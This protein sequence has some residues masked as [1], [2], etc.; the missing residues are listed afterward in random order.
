MLLN[1]AVQLGR[2][3]WMDQRFISLMEL[4]GLIRA[5][6]GNMGRFYK[7]GFAATNTVSFSKNLDDD[8]GLRFS[9]SDLHNTSIIPKCRVSAAV[10]FIIY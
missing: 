8:G 5:V 6:S 1:W 4:K 9:A 2:Q 7:N 10:I 3:N